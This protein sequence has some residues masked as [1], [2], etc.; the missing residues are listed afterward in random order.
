MLDPKLAVLR[1][2]LFDKAH[3]ADTKAG[4]LCDDWASKLGLTAGIPIAIGKLDAHYGAIC[5]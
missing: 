4:D 1:G 2:R 5:A 3:N